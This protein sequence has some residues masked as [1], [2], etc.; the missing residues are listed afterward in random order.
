[1]EYEKQIEAMDEYT[2]QWMPEN[3]DDPNEPI[4]KIT[5]SSLGSFNWCPKKYQFSYIERR[6]QDQTEAMR[7]GTIMHN[8]REDFFNNFDIKT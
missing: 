5:K 4:L 7:K 6:P 2:Y 8:S 3:M 1:M